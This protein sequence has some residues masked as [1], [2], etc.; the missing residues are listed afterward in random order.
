MI[1]YLFFMLFSYEVFAESRHKIVVID[2][3]V[4]FS[5]SLRSYM[6]KGGK[7]SI[8]G[9]WRDE[10]GHGTNIIGLIG[11]KINAKKT[12]IVS[13]K[14]DILKSKTLTADYVKATLM[15]EKLKPTAI[16]MSLAGEFKD[17]TEFGSLVRM[18]NSGV[19][20]IVASGNNSFNLDT[21]CV[22]YPAC[23]LQIMRYDRKSIKVNNFIVV[24]AKD[25]DRSNT[26]S[27]VTVFTEGKDQGTPK[28]SGTSQATANFTGRLFSK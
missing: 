26:G 12:C 28:L 15:A 27:V 11:E 7:L 19:K 10:H 23:Y 16:N 9:D 13:I 20:I 24:G 25:L 21:Q 4:S 3:G 18:V 6:C 2:T 8:S 5:Q 17:F 14:V 1:A 22:V